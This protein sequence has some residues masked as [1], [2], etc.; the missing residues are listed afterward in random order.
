MLQKTVSFLVLLFTVDFTEVISKLVQKKGSF[1]TIA[2]SDCSS[3]FYHSLWSKSDPSLQWTM[4]TATHQNICWW[5]VAIYFHLA[6]KSDSLCRTEGGTQ[7]NDWNSYQYFFL[8]LISIVFH[9]NRETLQL[10]LMLRY[11]TFK[12]CRQFTSAGNRIRSK[13]NSALNSL[14]FIVHSC[15]FFTEETTGSSKAHS[16][17][18]EHFPARQKNSVSIQLMQGL[19]K[20][21]ECLNDFHQSCIITSTLGN[22]KK[23]SLSPERPSHT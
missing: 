11:D 3:C 13:C 10:V 12:L 7:R 23:K 15:R 21:K 5:K 6:A 17:V 2:G 1:P 20:S 14:V 9:R 18:K 8:K 4:S 19:R 22:L 16:C